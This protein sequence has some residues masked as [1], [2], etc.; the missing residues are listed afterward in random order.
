M[1]HSLFLTAVLPGEGLQLKSVGI[2]G[3]RGKGAPLS[4]VCFNSGHGY[5]R[6]TWSE[7]DLA[8]IA[9]NIKE[10]RRCLGDSVKIMAVVKANAYGHG[11]CEVAGVALNAGACMLGVASLEEGMYLRSRGIA[12]PV[13]ILG[14]TAPGYAPLLHECSLTPTVFNWEGARD[15]AQ[16]ACA[17][18]CRIGFHFKVDTGM[19]RLGPADPNDALLLLGKISTLSGL[20]LE[21]VFTHFAAADEKDRKF[22]VRQVALFHQLL[23]AAANQALHIPLRHAANTAAA[24]EYPEAALDM[25]RLGI[26]IYG[27]YPSSAVDRQKVRLQGAFTLKSRIIFLKK[28][29]AGTPISYGGK[30]TA[31]RETLIATVPL[32]YGDG[33]NRHL[34]SGGSMLVRGRRVPIAGRVCMDMTMLDVGSLPGVREGDEVVA[35]G[36]QGSEEISIDAVATHLGTISYELLCNVSLRVPRLYFPSIKQQ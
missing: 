6:P 18:G 3:L 25:V 15:L 17:L 10:F 20:K 27:Y 12:A 29:P 2:C 28:V 9:S 13:L 36:Q 21:G 30:Y 16:Q 19:G 22:T 4:G 7:I 26:G 11:A 24:I 8:K 33:L 14:H 31:M 23:N 5:G 32:G 34:S 1:F 35:Y